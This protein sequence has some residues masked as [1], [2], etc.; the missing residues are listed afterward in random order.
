MGPE[1]LSDLSK[2]TQLASDLIFFVLSPKQVYMH[3][4]PRVPTQGLGVT[5]RLLP[6]EELALSLEKVEG[7]WAA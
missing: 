5:V 7:G 6:P 4:M 3:L 1:G 2:V